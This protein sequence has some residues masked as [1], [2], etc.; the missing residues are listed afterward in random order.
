MLQA[1]Q[2]VNPLIWLIGGGGLFLIGAA[3][4]ATGLFTVRKGKQRLCTIPFP[5]EQARQDKPIVRAFCASLIGDRPYQQDYALIPCSIPEETLQRKGCLCVLCDGMGGMRGGERASSRCAEG[6]FQAYYGGEYPSP[7]DFYQTEIPRMDE[8]VAGLKGENEAPLG[9]GTTLVSVLIQNGLAWFASVGDSRVYLYRGNTLHLLTRDHNYQLLLDEQAK[10][11]QITREEALTHPQREALISYIGM[12]GLRLMDIR[13]DGFA[14]TPGDLFLLCSDGLTKAMSEEELR[15]LIEA[16]MA[17]PS[18]L[19]NQLAQ[20]AF[21]KKWIAH[22]NI[23]A[24]IL[25]VTA[26]SSKV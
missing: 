17:E 13:K 7:A 25:A 3:L 5:Y 4:M 21:S 10:N 6:L 23:T 1:L 24:V 2:G 20:A 8:A 11:G 15:L 18:L 9:G 26:A 14:V 16:G 12:D 22:D 19:P